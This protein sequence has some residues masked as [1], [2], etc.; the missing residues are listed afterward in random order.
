MGWIEMDCVLVPP[1]AWA[2]EAFKAYRISP[3]LRR[4]GSSLR[5]GRGMC[6]TSLPGGLSVLGKSCW[7]YLTSGVQQNCKG[8]LGFVTL[9]HNNVV[10]IDR[11]PSPA[12]RSVSICSSLHGFILSLMLFVFVACLKWKRSLSL[13]HS[14][15]QENLQRWMSD[16]LN[17]PKHRH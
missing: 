1:T 8:T 9:V 12:K 13:R 17:A 4:S 15:E 11:V 14:L 7:S 6:H 2:H 10:K 3:R 5:L 16:F